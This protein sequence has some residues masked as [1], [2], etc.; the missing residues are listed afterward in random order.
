ME[1]PDLSRFCEESVALHNL[2]E[3]VLAKLAKDEGFKIPSEFLH[4]ESSF[5][6]PKLVGVA[7]AWAGVRRS[8]QQLQKLGQFDDA[9]ARRADFIA[10]MSEEGFWDAASASF[11][12]PPNVSGDELEIV[13]LSLLGP[14]FPDLAAVLAGHLK[15][16]Q[17]GIFT[18]LGKVLVG[19]KV[20]WGGQ[21]EET[22]RRLH[23]PPVYLDPRLG[24][25][26]FL[27]DEQGGTPAVH[28]KIEW[29]CGVD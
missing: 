2:W 4:L 6:W 10:S 22:L 28:R 27:D 17:P 18:E 23:E 11:F 12:S 24:K 21:Q 1:N 7:A 9:I 26:L 16:R 19:R 8:I 20:S 29:S 3:S 25:S 15:P 13:L 14:E 5:E